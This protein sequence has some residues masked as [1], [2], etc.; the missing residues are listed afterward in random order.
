MVNETSQQSEEMKSKRF[1]DIRILFY[2]T[3]DN[4]LSRNP[5]NIS[6]SPPRAIRNN[7]GKS[8]PMHFEKTTFDFRLSSV[9]SKMR[10]IYEYIYIK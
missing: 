6:P 8:N 9:T 4:T 2:H 1:E 10:S 7:C 3:A 5:G